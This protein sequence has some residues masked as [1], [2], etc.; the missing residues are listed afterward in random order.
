MPHNWNDF[1][2]NFINKWKVYP[3]RLQKDIKREL[4]D[5]RQLNGLPPH[6]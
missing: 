1:F 5:H 6:P 3:D 4:N 2:Y